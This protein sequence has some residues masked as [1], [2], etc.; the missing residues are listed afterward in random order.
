MAKALQ[1]AL[2]SAFKIII[3]C[4]QFVWSPVESVSQIK[5]EKNPWIVKFLELFFAYYAGQLPE[6]WMVHVKLHL[7]VNTFHVWFGLGGLNFV[8]P[9]ERSL[10]SEFPW[11]WLSAAP[12][13]RGVRATCP[14]PGSS[15]PWSPSQM[16]LLLHRCFQQWQETH[17]S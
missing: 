5:K 12:A 2:A 7:Y 8:W 15:G 14:G 16:I 3:F 1:T 4:S 13:R 9:K 17:L 10:Q 11:L 6:N